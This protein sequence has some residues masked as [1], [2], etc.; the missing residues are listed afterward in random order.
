M[1]PHS[2]W[3]V[4]SC[5]WAFFD[6]DD[7]FQLN[8]TIFV[9]SF[10][11]FWLVLSRPR[12]VFSLEIYSAWKWIIHIYTTFVHCITSSSIIL[13]CKCSRQILYVD[14]PA[15]NISPTTQPTVSVMLLKASKCI[16]FYEIDFLRPFTDPW[17]L[18][19]ILKWIH[20]TKTE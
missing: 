17:F 18:Q 5:H 1:L 3:Y 16:D 12:F 13:F 15:R 20:K 11:I 8:C 9:R 19:P 10:S 2:L 4:W 6:D 7:A 14:M